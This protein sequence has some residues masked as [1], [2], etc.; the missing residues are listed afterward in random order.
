MGHVILESG[1]VLEHPSKRQHRRRV[2]CSQ[3]A[4]LID[5]LACGQDH[6]WL[7]EDVFLD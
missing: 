5:C 4:P 7:I 3:F 1:Q 2:G 6:T